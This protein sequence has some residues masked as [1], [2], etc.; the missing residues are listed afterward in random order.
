MNN[1]IFGY[2]GLIGTY[3]TTMFD[4]KYFF[5][6]KNIELAKN[7]NFD[8]L[9]ITCIQSTKWYKNIELD[10]LMF[11][12][13]LNIL[14]TITA[15]KVILFSS[16]DVY[17][18]LDNSNESTI[19]NYNLN[20]NF[21]KNKYLFETEIISLFNNYHIIR[22]PVIFGNGLKKNIIFDLLNDV[23]E[24]NFN[25]TFQ[26]YNLENLKDD[27]NICINNNIKLC[28]LV[29]EPINNNE[30]IKLFNK[31]YIHNNKI[32]LINYN[33]K[34]QYYKLFNG[35][36]GFTISKE[37]ILINIQ[38]FI[39]SYNTNNLCI[40]TI[41]NIHNVIPNEQLYSIL[42]RYNIKYIELNSIPNNSISTINDLIKHNSLSL[43]SITPLSSFS[44]LITHSPLLP[45]SPLIPPLIPVIYN[46]YNIFDSTNH[47]LFIH[48]LNII[49]LAINNKIKNLI[50]NCPDNRKIIIDSDDNKYTFIYFFRKLGN[51]IG[52]NDLTILIENISINYGC[53]F[54]NSIMEVGNIVKEIDHPKIK[55]SLNIGSSVMDNDVLNNIFLYKN[56]I[57]YIHIGSPFMNVFT[58]SFNPIY[59]NKFI[60]IIKQIKYTGIISLECKCNTKEDI[61]TSINNFINYMKK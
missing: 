46:K 36:N 42:R 16:I 52:K 15:T 55:M 45:F 37:N 23:K 58:T 35:I 38:K 18:N 34:S 2:T 7:K 30:L 1:A 9:F 61:I 40:S 41:C 22:L 21:N 29:S 51:Y 5:N 43:N 24:I 48:L 56:V 19:I 10:K 27:I 59:Y 60:K 8:I 28:N 49:D 4:F 14:K 33:I 39:F 6:S 32:P 3:L 17:N 44:P 47:D 11:E 25:S 57:N 31:Q 54:L 26:F 13:I 50:F 53:N 12:N 20:N